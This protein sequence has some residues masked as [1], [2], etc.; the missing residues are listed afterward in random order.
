[1][2]AN[3]Y[4]GYISILKE[5]L[6]PAM[7]CTEPISVAYAAAIAEKTLKT[8]PER[9]EIS[10]SGNILYAS[11]ENLFAV[12]RNFHNVGVV[13]LDAYENLPPPQALTRE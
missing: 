7:G 5:E 9:V 3:T 1:M 2:D 13:P 8:L 4:K 11:A 6:L 12:V 10:V